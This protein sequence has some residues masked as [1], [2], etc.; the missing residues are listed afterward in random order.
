MV[1]FTLM[2]TSLIA[3][4]GGTGPSEETRAPFPSSTKAPS[5]LIYSHSLVLLILSPV[6]GWKT[7]IVVISIEHQEQ[8]GEMAW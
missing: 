2:P 1:S 6:S 4:G 7:L 3:A 5:L 8:A